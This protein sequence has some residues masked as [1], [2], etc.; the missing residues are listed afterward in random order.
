MPTK[1]NAKRYTILYGFHQTSG[2]A[3]I[4]GAYTTPA[5]I[6]TFN[7][8]DTFTGVEN[9]NW[10]SQVRRAVNATTDASGTVRT[11]RG[12]GPTSY[13]FGYTTSTPQTAAARRATN[14]WPSNV[15]WGSTSAVAND[16]LTQNIARARFA[17]K[18]EKIYTQ[19]QGGVFLGE[20]RETLHMIRN[21]A[22]SLRNKLGDH[23]ALLKRK[24]GRLRRLPRERR[25]RV[26]Q[27]MWLE[28]SFGWLPLLNDLDDARSYL[29]KRQDALYRQVITV[30]SGHELAWTLSESAQSGGSGA[31]PLRWSRLIR[32]KC[33]HVLAGGVK[34]TASSKKLI[35][36]SAMGLAPRNF[37][38]TLWELIPWSFAVDYFSNVGDVIQA[39]SSQSVTLAWGRETQRRESFTDLI[40]QRDDIS[41]LRIVR[42]HNFIPGDYHAYQK[43]WSRA[44][45][46]VPPVPEVMFELPGFG[47]KWMNLAALA[48]AKRSI[49][50]G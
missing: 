50:L 21:P 27:S 5:T 19:F 32:R 31:N 48:S 49:K 30:K 29:D 34:S 12:V 3:A 43:Q 11:F 16:L 20:L 41:T 10:R 44:K 6:G 24:Q 40:N 45:I 4:N 25:E 18:A 38:P 39:W 9:R 13:V 23:L 42:D 26:V 22:K 15:E 46:L 33:S 1:T 35:D 7:G 47:L 2:S 28:A 17:K 36:R 8:D 14:R 37:V